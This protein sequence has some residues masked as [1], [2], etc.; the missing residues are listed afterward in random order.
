LIDSRQLSSR[1]VRRRPNSSLPGTIA[2]TALRD[3]APRCAHPSSHA[4][5]PGEGLRSLFCSLSYF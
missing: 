3:R 5:I 1:S 2:R 4:R